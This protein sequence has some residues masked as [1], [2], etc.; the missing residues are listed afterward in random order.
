MYDSQLFILQLGDSIASLQ[1][2]SWDFCSQKITL[3]RRNWDTRDSKMNRDKPVSV[4]H[5]L[6]DVTAMENYIWTALINKPKFCKLSDTRDL[7]SNLACLDFH[8]PL[9]GFEARA[10]EVLLWTWPWNL[11]SKEDIQTSSVVYMISVLHV[12]LPVLGTFLD[13]FVKRL[14]NLDVSTNTVKWLFLIFS[15]WEKQ[16]FLRIKKYLGGIYRQT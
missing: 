10:F 2:W 1:R 13:C 16:T 11:T 15:W 12:Y 3:Q 4:F 8:I 7:R 14:Y 5:W 6:R 9:Y